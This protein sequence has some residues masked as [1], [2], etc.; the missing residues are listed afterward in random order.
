[1]ELRQ[2]GYT[3]GLL[4]KAGMFGCNPTPYPM[5][6]REQLNK[7]NTGK[8]VD[9]TVY[10]SL[11]GG[12]T[13]L[14][15]TRPDIWY[16]V[17]MVSCYMERPTVKHLN[18]V[19]RIFCYVSGTLE[20]GLLYTENSRNHLMSGYFYSDLGG[21]MDDRK[22]TSGIAFYLS[23][24]LVTWVS[25]KQRCVALSSCEAEFMAA[26]AAACQGIWLNN[27][28]SR[29]MDVNIGPVVLYIDNQ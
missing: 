20:Y 25:Q 16:A 18:A 21:N 6:P 7:D 10:K 24:S 27:L 26:T 12:L 2:T 9:S 13:F 3:K 17:G 23:E 22:R 19:K 11:V 5:E 14:V 28:L 4:K 1:M 15:H 8:V 29:I